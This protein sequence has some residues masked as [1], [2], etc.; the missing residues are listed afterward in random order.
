MSACC[1]NCRH[2][3]DAAAELEALLPGLRTLG[4]AYGAVRG[5]DGICE[6][7]GRYLTASSRCREHAWRTPA[8]PP[9]P[10]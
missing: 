9:A 3:R 8:A 6:R 7:H 2:F 1:G 10:R 5:S 4:S